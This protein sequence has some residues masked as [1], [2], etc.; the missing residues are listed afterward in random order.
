MFLARKGSVHSLCGS[1]V[2]SSGYSFQ[3][4][5]RIDKG[6]L[7]VVH[8]TTKS[9]TDFVFSFS[10]LEQVDIIVDSTNHHSVRSL[11]TRK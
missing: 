11:K 6:Q 5:S 7:S 8:L 10:S 2:L 9:I 4:K 3:I 1:C